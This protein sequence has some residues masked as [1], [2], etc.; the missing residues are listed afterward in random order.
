MRTHPSFNRFVLF[1]LNLLPLFFLAATFGHC[2]VI[3]KDYSDTLNRISQGTGKA[4][5]LYYAYL[6]KT[7]L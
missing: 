7:P 2:Y 5:R 6:L 1:W 4:G 3:L